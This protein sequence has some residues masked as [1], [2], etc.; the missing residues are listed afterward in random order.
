MSPTIEQV[1]DLAEQLAINHIAVKHTDGGKIAFVGINFQQLTEDMGNPKIKFPLIA[2]CLPQDLQESSA[3]NFSVSG[4]SVIKTLVLPFVVYNNW[5]KNEPREIEAKISACQTILD[6]CLIRL[7]QL[8][9]EA[10]A[11]C[12]WY[13]NL[14]IGV[15][16]QYVVGP[17]NDGIIG[18]GANVSFTVEEPFS[19]SKTNQWL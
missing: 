15:V 17:A 6:D 13:K 8:A 5:D 10:H 11:T 7:Q 16:S 2:L 4:T 19:L 1:Y 12:D 14:K 18:V 3:A 9:H